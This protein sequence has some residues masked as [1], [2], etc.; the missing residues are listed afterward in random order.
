MGTA[1]AGEAEGLGVGAG[2]Q[3]AG[4]LLAGLDGGLFAVV[5]LTAAGVVL[6][7]A[8]VVPTAAGAVFLVVVV[9]PTAA[10][11]VFPVAVVV[12][13]AAGIVLSVAVVMSAVG[14]RACSRG[15]PRLLQ[16]EGDPR[17][18][19][20]ADFLHGSQLPFADRVI[21]LHQDDAGGKTHRYLGKE[22][23]LL[24][25]LL[26]FHG[27]VGAA[28][29]FKVDPLFHKKFPFSIALLIYPM[30]E[31]WLTAWTMMVLTWSSSRE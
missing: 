13:T 10:G 15:S 4:G 25:L 17:L 6:P 27:A 22:L 7:V 24:Q 16:G 9:V 2:S 11:V 21:A 1:E 20:V 8:V 14:N 26:N 23:P 5:V 19:V 31:M 29:M 3:F 28:E 30:W 12:S 18:D